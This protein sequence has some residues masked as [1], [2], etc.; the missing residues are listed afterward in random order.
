MWRSPASAFA[1]PS[2]QTRS[3][4]CWR[5]KTRPGLSRRAARRSNSVRVSGSR[6]LRDRQDHA[7]R[8]SRSTRRRRS[9]VSSTFSFFRTP[10]SAASRLRSSPGCTPAGMTSSAPEPRASR[11]G[12][13]KPSSG[14]VTSAIRQ[15]GACSRN[16][17]IAAAGRGRVKERSMRATWPPSRAASGWKADGAARRSTR[18]PSARK[19]RVQRTARSS[20]A[21][22]RQQD[23]RFTGCEAGRSRC[24]GS[25]RGL[26]AS[27]CRRSD[28]TRRTPSRRSAWGRRR[29]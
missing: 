2:G 23:R 20:R 28:G 21:V 14:S 24:G 26:P 11:M 9:A 18:Q 17:A 6:R 27:S 7:C 5:V 4:S 3:M 8:R 1:S 19:T 22:T 29:A 16:L 13:P 12:V 15:P 10:A 25:S